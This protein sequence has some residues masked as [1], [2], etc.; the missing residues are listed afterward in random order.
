MTNL[1][2]NTSYILSNKAERLNV[3]VFWALTFLLSAFFLVYIYSV[4]SIVDLSYRIEKELEL[5]KNDGIF[6]QEVEEKYMA[7]L[8]SL[9]DEGRESL[10]LASAKNPLF[11]ER[12][13]S[14][15]RAQGFT[16]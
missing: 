7:K 6:Y 4:Y 2:I 8:E 16:Q 15:A 5:T 9:F 11:V 1:K 10:G 3:R 14:L 13:G 12:F